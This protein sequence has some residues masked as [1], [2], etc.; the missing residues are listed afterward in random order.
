MNLTSSVARAASHL[1]ACR[2]QL[3]AVARREHDRLAARQ[4]R[5]QLA[6]RRIQPARV[7]VDP[8]AQ[9]DGRGPVTDS[10]EQKMHGRIQI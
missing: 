2:I 7:E 4:P 1:I 5:R 8:L 10:D 3:G 9:L 6:Q